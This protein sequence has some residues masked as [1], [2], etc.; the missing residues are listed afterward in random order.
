M[1]AVVVIAH[2]LL[3][4]G[5]LPVPPVVLAA[6]AVLVVL[7]VSLRPSGP[8]R[9]PQPGPRQD[10]QTPQDAPLRAS[11]IPG[12]AL[13]LV[14]L[15]G[16]IA[17]GLVGRNDPTANI[18]PALIIGVGWPLL[19]A[20]AA[21]L[22]RLWQWIDP[23]DTLA[24]L[25]APL[26]RDRGEQAAPP[27]VWLAVP[28]AA[29]LV[30]YLGAYRQALLPRSVA[31][32]LGLYTIVT[33]AGCLAMGRR[34]WLHRAEVVGIL[35]GWIGLIRRRGLETWSAPHGAAVVL[36]VVA[37]GLLFA[38]L[39]FSR[40][41]NPLVFA[42]PN[43]PAEAVGVAVLAIAGAAV[44]WAGEHVC[45]RVA[46]SGTV[47]A[48]VVPVV[49]GLALAAAMV[50]GQLVLALQLLP[51][52]AS[53]PLGRGWDLFGTADLP[54][55]ANPLGDAVHTAVQLGVLVA[56]GAAGGVVAR[57]RAALDATSGG[58]ARRAVSTAAGVVSLLVAAGVLAT[59]AV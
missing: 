14:V 36:G 10:P 48:A 3:E 29:A 18:A 37:G 17:A 2:P 51:R 16:A 43:V 28:G 19:V 33:L 15:V 53:D 12:R 49:A 52:L 55:A 11:V 59:T 45:R 38:M 27:A 40:L 26:T 1:Q 23:W 41:L 34:W 50:R 30:W 13:G 56:A 35:L 57:R 6:V 58:T 5:G 31:V 7:A 32:A 54:L 20:A 4:P 44:V 8:Q 47:A 9:R 42:L 46:A 24:R 22:G 39:R 25:A 21:V